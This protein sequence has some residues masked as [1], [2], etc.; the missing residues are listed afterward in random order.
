MFLTSSFQRTRQTVPPY[1]AH[2]TLGFLHGVDRMKSKYSWP[3]DV[4]LFIISLNDYFYAGVDYFYAGVVLIFMH[5]KFNIQQIFI[6]RYTASA[7]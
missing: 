4:G 6:T 3:D 2:V 1:F 7:R 5:V